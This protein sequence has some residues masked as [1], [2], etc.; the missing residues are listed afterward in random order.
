MACSTPLAPVW[1]RLAASG[2][3]RMHRPCHPALSG[4]GVRRLPSAS[5][6]HP[7]AAGVE[8]TI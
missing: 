6:G 7:D 8:P 1:P 3:T 5:L 2:A 4:G